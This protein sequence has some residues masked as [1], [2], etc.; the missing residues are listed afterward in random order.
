MTRN[1]FV[2]NWAV[3]GP[4]GLFSLPPKHQVSANAKRFRSGAYQTSYTKCFFGQAIVS[5][6]DFGNLYRKSGT[7]QK[8]VVKKEEIP[9]TDFKSSFVCIMDTPGSQNTM[10]RSANT[11]RINEER[12]AACKDGQLAASDHGV[13]VSQDRTQRGIK[14]HTMSKSRDPC[15]GY[16]E[17][18]S[19]CYAQKIG[20]SF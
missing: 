6:E 4:G 20:T 19:K 16:P 17:R 11:K 18:T 10:Q 5:N 12:N 7:A 15:I 13:N 8:H 1:A 3:R 9:R 2:A 14:K